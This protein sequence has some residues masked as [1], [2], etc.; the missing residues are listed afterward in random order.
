MLYAYAGLYLNLNEK[1]DVNDITLTIVE[2]RYPRDLIRHLTGEKNF[3]VEENSPGIY[4][5]NGDVRK[6]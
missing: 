1:V 2:S 3:T 6:V 5:V 4:T